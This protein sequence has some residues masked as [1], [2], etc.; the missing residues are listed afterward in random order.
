MSVEIENSHHAYGAVTG[1]TGAILSGSGFASART[2]KG[3]YTL[4][5]DEP[6][7]STE[8]SIKVSVRGGAL[9]TTA[10]VAHTSDTVKTVTTGSAANAAAD[11]D[12]DFCILRA[13][14][15]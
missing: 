8:C 5:L 10:Q 2:G 15:T 9:G 13:A 14:D 1:A 11:L 4:T 3:I 7:D 6:V 12:F